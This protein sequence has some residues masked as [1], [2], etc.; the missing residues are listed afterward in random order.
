MRESKVTKEARELGKILRLLE[1]GRYEKAYNNVNLWN[2]SYGTVFP[3]VAS[4]IDARALI[5]RRRAKIK[6]KV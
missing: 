1:N 6:K 3:I 4:D 5:S 2:Q